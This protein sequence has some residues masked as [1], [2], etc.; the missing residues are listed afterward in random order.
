MIYRIRAHHGMCFSFFQGKGYSG[1]FTDN[2]WAMKEKLN[3]NPEVMLLCETDDVC[4]HCPNNRVGACTSLDQ[5]ADYDRQVLKQCGLTAG[6][7]IRW[8]DFEKL[9]QNKILEPGRREEICGGCEWNEL[10]SGLR[11]NCVKRE[12]IRS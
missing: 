10:C 11:K 9:V 2:M 4:A 1:E 5:V 8:N 3:E 12:K 7:R 6:I